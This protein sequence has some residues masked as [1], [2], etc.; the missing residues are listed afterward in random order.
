MNIHQQHSET[1]SPIRTDLLVKVFYDVVAN[2]EDTFTRFNKTGPYLLYKQR[3][4]KM[5]KEFGLELKPRAATVMRNPKVDAVSS[6]PSTLRKQSMNRGLVSPPQ[7]AST[8]Q[9]Q[10]N[11][12]QQ[13]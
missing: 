12:E 7:E 10:P 3:R 2:L 6:E 11:K 4:E 8:D 13:L 1:K 5:K 9:V